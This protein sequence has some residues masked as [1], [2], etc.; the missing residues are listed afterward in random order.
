MNSPGVRRPSRVTITRIVFGLLLLAAVPSNAAAVTLI[1]RSTGL[2]SP[3]KE[4]GHTEYEVGDVNGDGHLD[5]ISVGDHGSPYVNSS[6]HGI[7]IW[8]GNG[9]G[10]WTVY[11]YGSFGYG[12]CAL[13]DLNLDGYLDVAW[14]L[15]H[16]WG[17]GMGDRL[18]SAAIGNGSG[19]TWTDWGVGLATSGEDWGMFATALADFNG[20]G[21]LDIV[22]QSF[23]GSN[24][25]RIYESHGNGSWSPAW[26]LVGG[27]VCYT[28]ETCDINADGAL[29][30]VSTRSG[31]YVLLGNGDFGFAV[32]T[33]GLPAGT[34]R[35]IEAGD[36]NNDGLQDIAFGFGSAGVRCY[37]YDGDGEQWIDASAGLPTSGSYDL[38]QFGDLNGDGFLDIVAFRDP[39]GCVYLGNGSGTWSADATWQMPSPGNAS[40]MRVDGDID[41]DGREDIVIQ[42]TMSGFPFYRNQLRVYSPWQEP[43]GLTARVYSPHGG[44]TFKAE[45]L[46]FIRWLA[47]V[48]PVQGEATVDIKLSLNGEA[49]PWTTL[50]SDL[51]NSGSFQWTVDAPAN[52]DRCRIQ[53]VVATG[54]DQATSISPADFRIISVPFSAVGDQRERGLPGSAAEFAPL[55]LRVAPNPARESVRVQATLPPGTTARVLLCDVAGRAVRFGELSWNRPVVTLP[56]CDPFGKPLPT[57]VYLAVL[58]TTRGM[59][60]TRF[61]IL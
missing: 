61:V 44:E 54:T 49:G 35:C 5:L 10:N 55:S 51:P 6:E 21:W 15:H 34:F 22:S 53:V 40:A 31:S 60:T 32:H 2:Q 58:Q 42:A 37:A 1:S 52:S 29:D 11:Q 39:T 23:G 59:R 46:R 9:S 18:I 26:A 13:G 27:S 17:G 50:A 3:E 41:H 24:G 56:L 25:I 33:S 57:G 4:E 12:G 47:A 8:L 43:S 38:V 16:D 7:M 36:I 45:S 20:D 19:Y 28:L 14:G 48:P 30:I